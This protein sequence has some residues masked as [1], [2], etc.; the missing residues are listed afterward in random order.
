MPKIDQW[1]FQSQCPPTPLC[2]APRRPDGGQPDLVRAVRGADPQDAE[3]GAPEEEA[4]A[5]KEEGLRDKDVPSVSRG[6]SN[7]LF[8]PMIHIHFIAGLPQ[9]HLLLPPGQA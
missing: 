4:R 5:G 2:Q 1:F 7:F 8:T 6:E 9:V 3:G